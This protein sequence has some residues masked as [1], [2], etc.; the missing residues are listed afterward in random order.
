[1][2][3]FWWKH[4]SEKCSSFSSTEYVFACL[5]DCFGFC[6]QNLVFFEH[7]KS[8]EDPNLHLTVVQSFVGRGGLPLRYLI[9]FY[10]K[11]TFQECFVILLS[12]FAPYWRIVW[13]EKYN[14]NNNKL[15][16]F[17]WSCEDKRLQ[18]QINKSRNYLFL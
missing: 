12:S 7:L 16:C 11:Q 1:M 2:L 9:F 18:Q 5:P 14:K 8:D 3:F 13:T 10:P 17:L 6:H 15:V 4:L